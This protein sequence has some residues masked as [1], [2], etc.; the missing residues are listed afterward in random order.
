MDS[1]VQLIVL[2]FIL[3]AIFINSYQR[4]KFRLSL[5]SIDCPA[6]AF[7]MAIYISYQN[8]I[9]LATVCTD[10]YQINN[11]ACNQQSSDTK[12]K[13][14]TKYCGQS[15]ILKLRIDWRYLHFI[16]LMTAILELGFRTISNVRFL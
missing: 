10:T 8:C 12:N 5:K 1:N 2:G 15:F 9:L 3:L 14:G 4:N 7:K 16:Y 11:A 6:K 13:A